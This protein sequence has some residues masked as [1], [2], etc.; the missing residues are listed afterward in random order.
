MEGY[1]LLITESQKD[2][3]GD[4]G[5]RLPS[6]LGVALLPS[7]RGFH[8]ARNRRMSRELA[9]GQVWKQCPTLPPSYPGT[10]GTMGRGGGQAGSP[11]VGTGCGRRCGP[12]KQLENLHCK[13]IGNACLG[14]NHDPTF[15]RNPVKECFS[16]LKPS[17][18]Q[19][20]KK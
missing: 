4:L 3:V 17:V 16:L 5:H 8:R 10:S 13:W 7:T 1:F 15:E 14:K 6:M 20:F 2:L 18:W 11:A 12:G 9:C 19:L